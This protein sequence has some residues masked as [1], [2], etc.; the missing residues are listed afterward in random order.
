MVA[1]GLY[2]VVAYM[3]NIEYQRLIYAKVKIQIYKSH[4]ES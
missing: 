2:K 1:F 4:M 3:W